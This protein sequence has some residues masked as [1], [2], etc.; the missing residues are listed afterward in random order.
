MTQVTANFHQQ[1]KLV[2]R[3]LIW[4]LVFCI[5][6]FAGLVALALAFVAAPSQAHAATPIE[7]VYIEYQKRV[8][9]QYK[10]VREPLTNWQPGEMSAFPAANAYAQSFKLYA[11]QTERNELLPQGQESE[12]YNPN[13]N[14]K[15]YVK[16]ENRTYPGVCTVTIGG[17][18]EYSGSVTKTFPVT[19]NL[20]N[21]PVEVTGHEGRFA[22][23]GQEV[24]LP[25]LKVRYKDP[26]TDQYVE[27]PQA[28]NYTVSYRNN[29]SAGTGIVTLAAVPGGMCSGITTRTFE[30]SKDV[31]PGTTQDAATN[32]GGASTSLAPTESATTA[33]AVSGAWKKGKGGKWWFAYD[34][35]SIA[36]RGK[37]FPAN[38]WV[39]V[40]GK[41]YRFDE[42]GYM[43][44]GWKQLGSQWYYLGGSSDGAMKTNKWVKTSGTWYYLSNE[45]SML[46]GKQAIGNATYL[47]DTS[48]GAMKT[49][50]QVADGAWHYFKSSGEMRTGWVKSGGKWYYLSVSGPM[51]TGKQPISGKTYLL[52]SNSGA[53]VTGWVREGI[54]WYHYNKSSGAQT[55]GWIK[56]GKDWYFMSRT[57]GEMRTGWVEDGGKRYYTNSEGKMLTGLVRTGS[58]ANKP[59]YYYFDNSGA[60]LTNAWVG[61]NFFGPDGKLA[62]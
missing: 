44:T 25:N 49:G 15:W 55:T 38:D 43:L 51:V 21:T 53:M 45:G 6:A 33:P 14:G 58:D 20:A 30:I 47:L 28:G 22:Y 13:T 32:N 4:A 61:S 9:G 26:A 59:E 12:I 5:A 46:K 10:T 2:S 16:Y 37:D 29:I 34:V 50:W 60:M 39:K 48:S 24:R 7:N 27:I 62:S 41:T 56:S 54:H 40:G 17:L 19:V 35:A 42:G 52:D 36:A 11:S 18:G 57:N 1:S 31:K 23:T 3:N 8:D